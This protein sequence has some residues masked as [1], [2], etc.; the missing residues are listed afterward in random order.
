MSKEKNLHAVG[1]GHETGVLS[2]AY[3]THDRRLLLIVGEALASKVS[4]A[5]LGY[6]DNDGRFDVS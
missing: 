4:G 6:L 3:G 2:G 1:L 5:T